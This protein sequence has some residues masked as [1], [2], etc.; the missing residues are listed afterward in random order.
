VQDCRFMHWTGQAGG[1]M[2]I[3]PGSVK[4][5]TTALRVVMVQLHKKRHVRA[6]PQKPNGVYAYG[7]PPSSHPEP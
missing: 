7:Q 2:K 3:A 4:R 5:P 6:V 1:C